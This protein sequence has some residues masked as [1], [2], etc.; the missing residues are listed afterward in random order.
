MT[1]DP[2]GGEQPD[3]RRDPRF[4]GRLEAELL[5]DGAW[6]NCWIRDL[7]LGGAGLDPPIPAALGKTVELRSRR[8]D[9]AERLRGRVVNLA[10]RRT[11]MT[12]DLDA[13]TRQLLVEFLLAN[14]E[15]S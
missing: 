9:F 8:F 14:A 2:D 1:T 12:F 15:A 4:A 5:V 3:E 13:Q 7:S 6:W 10:E 11:C